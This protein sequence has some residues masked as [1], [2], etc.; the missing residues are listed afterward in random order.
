MKLYTSKRGKAFPSSYGS[1]MIISNLNFKRNIQNM[2]INTNTYFSFI[3]NYLE[4]VG[5]G[6]I[7]I[8]VFSHQ[9]N[10]EVVGILPTGLFS[11]KKVEWE[12]KVTVPTKLSTGRASEFQ[13]GCSG[14]NQ[15]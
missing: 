12:L 10:S 3:S 11:C 2:S 1:Q 6:I 4:V 8:Y 14:Q 9:L 15:I 13:G 5:A 7:F